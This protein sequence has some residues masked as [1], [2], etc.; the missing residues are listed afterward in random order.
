MN[1]MDNS[2]TAHIALYMMAYN[3][4]RK[5]TSRPCDITVRN[6]SDAPAPRAIRNP[7]SRVLCDTVYDVTPYRP[8][9]ASNNARL[10]SSLR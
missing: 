5:H 7:N 1:R 10:R 6:R 3:F 2:K 4:Q 9:A 8:I